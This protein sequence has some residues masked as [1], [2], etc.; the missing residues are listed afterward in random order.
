[1]AGISIA[2]ATFN[3]EE[4]IGSCLEALKDFSGEI[5]VVDGSSTDKTVEIAK[6]YGARV[7]VTTNKPIF[8]INK[9]MATDACHGD[10]ILQLDADEVVDQKLVSFIKR[11]NQNISKLNKKQLAV[12]QPKA[13]WLKRKN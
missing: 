2:L 10:W 9:Q 6:E 5:I 12:C 7:I 8:H 11:L 13:W 1:M 4:N 3:E